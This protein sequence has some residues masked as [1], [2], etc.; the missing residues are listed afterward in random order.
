M[1]M[2][3][4]ALVGGVAM[5][6][7]DWLSD[8]HAVAVS[9]RAVHPLLYAFVQLPPYWTAATV[10]AGCLS[11]ALTWAIAAQVGRRREARFGPQRLRADVRVR[12]RDQ[13]RAIA[14]LQS[15]LLDGARQYDDLRQLA[16]QQRDELSAIG[17][18]LK[19]G[20][21]VDE[22]TERRLLEGKVVRSLP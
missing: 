3:A 5:T 22:V 18:V 15:R 21:K 17:Q 12:L 20:N 19:L 9:P 6:A 8:Q 16:I 14:G 1:F 10:A 11:L 13:D 4:G 7:W 2:L